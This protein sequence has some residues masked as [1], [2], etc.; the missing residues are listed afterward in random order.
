MEKKLKKII[1]SYFQRFEFIE[2]LAIFKRYQQMRWNHM[3]DFDQSRV[4]IFYSELRLHINKVKGIYLVKCSQLWQ[5]FCR[6]NRKKHWF[7]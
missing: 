7:S 3:I 2:A 6:K 5:S 1:D 4:R